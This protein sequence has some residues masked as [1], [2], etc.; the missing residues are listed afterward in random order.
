[1]NFTK[2]LANPP[3]LGSLGGKIMSFVHDEYLNSE[4]IILMPVSNYKSNKLY[5]FVKE[6]QMSDP[7]FFSEAD[8]TKQLCICKVGN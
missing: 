4:Y 3:Y 8:L 7:K 2:I 1:M 6:I 5:S